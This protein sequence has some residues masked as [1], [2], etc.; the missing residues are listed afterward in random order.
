[1]KRDKIILLVLAFLLA[2]GLTVGLTGCSGQKTETM[3]LGVVL[4][5][6][7]ELLTDSNPNPTY[8]SIGGEWAVYGLANWDGEVPNDAWFDTYYANLESYVKDCKGVLNDRK[9][10]EYSRVILA[11]TAMGKDPSDVAGYNLLEPLADFDQTVFQ[12]IN[13][14]A[15]ALMALDSGNY[16]VPKVKGEGTQA[17]RD[18]YIDYI[19]SKEL[20]G[21]GWSLSGGDSAEADITAMV[22]QAL[23]KYRDREDVNA[24]VKRGVEALASLQGADGSYTSYGTDSSETISQ[25]IAALC[26]L[27]ISTD[28][29]RFVIDGKSLADRLLE[30]RTE[31]GTFRHTLDGEGDMMATE[32]AFY[33]LVDLYQVQNK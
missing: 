2:L 22:L 23:A 5:E 1:M 9:Y 27:G 11:L 24:A 15:Y 21:G 7:A 20:D 6:T 31:D 28:D 25:V 16:E 4:R 13:G 12:G 17:S 26:Q 33:A 32:Q 3:D 30:Y 14:P 18:I 10:T 29:Q 19:L 8:G